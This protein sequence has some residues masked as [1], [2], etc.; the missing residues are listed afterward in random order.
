[1]LPKGPRVKDLV[2]RDGRGRYSK[3]MGPLGVGPD[4]GLQVTEG[5]CGIPAS[6]SFASWIVRRRVGL[7]IH[8][9]WPH[10]VLPQTPN[11]RAN[12][13]ETGTSKTEPK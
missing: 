6:P 9:L 8:V 12:S 2:P 5:D 10:A 7:I 4:G 1:M 3:V 11:I 13:S